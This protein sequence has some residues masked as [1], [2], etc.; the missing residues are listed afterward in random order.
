MNI[1]FNSC[2]Y[3]YYN[4]VMMHSFELNVTR[5]RT[6]LHQSKV[7]DLR[8]GLRFRPISFSLFS[9]II[10]YPSRSVRYLYTYKLQPTKLRGFSRQRYDLI[11]V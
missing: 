10:F 2:T 8:I 4:T 3:N 11:R 7:I 6:S 5:N 9:G 1:F